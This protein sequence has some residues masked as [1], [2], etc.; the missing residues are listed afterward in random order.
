MM[1]T[2]VAAS[3]FLFLASLSYGYEACGKDRQEALSNL[4]ASILSNVSTSLTNQTSVETKSGEEKI[5]AKIESLMQVSSNLSF[6]NTA[7][8]TREN[9]ICASVDKDEQIENA[10]LQ[11]K[12]SLALSEANLPNEIDAKA[13]KLSEWIDQLKRTR[14]LVIAFLKLSNGVEED[15]Q[16]VLAS[17]QSKEK[18]FGDLYDDTILKADS[19]VFKACENGKEDAYK[20]LNKLLFKSKT[21]REDDEGIMSKASSFF[22]A[23][24]PF[25]KKEEKMLDLFA[26]EVSYVKSDKKECALI[27]KESLLSVATALNQELGRFSIASLSKEP[28]ERYNEIKAFEQHVNVTKALLELFAEKF[29]KADFNRITNVKKELANELENTNPQYILFKIVGEADELR[30]KLADKFVEPNKKYYLKEGEYA[31]TLSA[32]GKCPIK[33]EVSLKLLEDEMIERDFV[34]MNLPV[35]TFYTKEGTRIIADGKILKPN[36]E[37]VIQRCE[38]EIKYI[39]DYEGQNR[40]ETLS[41]SPNISKT[42]EL[43]FLSAEE[44]AIFN[45]AKT[46]SFETASHTPFSDSLTPT[47]SKNL[48][49][50]V[51][52]DVKNG[53]LELHKSGT[54]TY[55]SKDGFVGIDSFKYYVKANGEKSAPKVVNISVNPSNA[56]L[57]PLVAPTQSDANTTAQKVE[58]TKTTIDEETTKKSAEAEER[59]QKFKAYVDSQ[60]Q[61]V[62]KLQKLKERYPDLF[63]RL[64]KEKLSGQ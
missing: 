3:T 18:R 56:P 62:E 36:V 37:N 4:S 42:I 13:A 1:K 58:E 48:E 51:D 44:L 9:S 11:L 35:L 54:F 41:L 2:W 33:G 60:E 47:I 24:N 29:T 8:S 30:I 20:S 57:I 39:A 19:L 34:S 6:V 46:K 50:I 53:S 49:F 14:N 63:E 17:L 23:L 32:K 27:K 43:K 31:Y 12:D 22:S 10:K 7:F 26:K 59:Y 64:L 38:G 55:T 21:K 40:E 16:P 45:N 15:M 28:K 5:D 52:S 25:G 61:N